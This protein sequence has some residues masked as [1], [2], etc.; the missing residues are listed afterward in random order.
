MFPN[1]LI[2]LQYNISTY[3]LIDTM[4]LDIKNS[5]L[6]FVIKNQSHS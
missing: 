1:N 4:T 5:K 3:L 6:Y 2:S